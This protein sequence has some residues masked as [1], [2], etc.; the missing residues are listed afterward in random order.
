MVRQVATCVGVIDGDTFETDSKL[1]VRL[2]RVYTAELSTPEGVQA[3]NV[4]M[5]MINGRVIIYEVVAHD[6]YGRNI[7][8]VWV[9]TI[10]VNDLMIARGYDKP[11]W[12]PPPPPDPEE[13]PLPEP[14]VVPPLIVRRSVKYKACVVYHW[15]S[16]VGAWH[17]APNQY[18]RLSAGVYLINGNWLLTLKHGAHLYVGPNVTVVPQ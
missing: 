14:S 2:A 16:L 3:R 12:F 7:C 17:K 9:N 1:R 18:F 10:N 11:Q 6:D 8:E 5:S 13:V 15:S 4:L